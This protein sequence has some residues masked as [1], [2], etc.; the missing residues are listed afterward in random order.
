MTPPEKPQW[1]RLS[2]KAQLGIVGFIAGVLTVLFFIRLY[3]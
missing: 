3:R 1:P 2:T